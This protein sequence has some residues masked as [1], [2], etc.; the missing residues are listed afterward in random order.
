MFYQSSLYICSETH[1]KGNTFDISKFEKYTTVWQS[2]TVYHSGDICVNNNNYWVCKD[3]HTSGSTFSAKEEA[4]WYPL[5]ACMSND[6]TIWTMC[7]DDNGAIYA[8]VYAHSFRRNPAIYK[9]EDGGFT[10]RYQYNFVT[11]GAMPLPEGSTHVDGGARHVHCINFNEYDHCLYAAVGEVNTLCKSSD[12]GETWVDLDMPFYY[13]QPTM[14]IGAKDGTLIGSDGHYSC[15]V[16]KLTPDGKSV[17][18]CGRTCPGFIFAMRRSDVTG[19]IYA[20]TRCDNVTGDIEKCPPME[21]IDNSDVLKEWKDNQASP[22]WLAIWELYHDWATKFYPKDAIRPTHSVIMVSKDEGETW[23]VIRYENC[24]TN[25]ASIC[26]F[27][28]TGYFRNGECLTGLLKSTEGTVNDKHFV[29]PIVISEGV[30]NSSGDVYNLSGEIFIKTN[31]VVNVSRLAEVGRND[32]G[33]DVVNGKLFMNNLP[34]GCDVRVY[35]LKGELIYTKTMTQE[36]ASIN[37]IRFNEHILI[38]QIAG[39]KLKIV[40]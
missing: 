27:I 9:S 3:A 14:I 33:L 32:I 17:K 22:E 40:L 38:I 36:T 10:W 35:S 25:F 8:G 16:S 2:A 13:G 28:T 4:H 30:K 6:D 23:E 19:W 26:G 15:G 5:T 39:K 31:A 24:N 11:N 29:C 1:T 20:F 37:L 21:A 7:E 18:P 12:F 34:Y